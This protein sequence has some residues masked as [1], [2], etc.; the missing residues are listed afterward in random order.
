[1]ALLVDRNRFIDTQIFSAG[2]LLPMTGARPVRSSCGH[3][4]I[5]R[6]HLQEFG[7]DRTLVRRFSATVCRAA[8]TTRI[9]R[10]PAALVRVIAPLAAYQASIV[11]PPQQR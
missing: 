7:S 4:V 5:D 8:S 2:L 10:N 1:M 9:A 3:G 6:R 11:D